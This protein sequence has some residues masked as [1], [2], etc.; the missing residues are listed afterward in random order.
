MNFSQL[1]VHSFQHFLYSAEK[2]GSWG[3]ELEKISVKNIQHCLGE[4]ETIAVDTHSTETCS[5]GR[6]G[7]TVV[8][9]PGGL[10]DTMVSAAWKKV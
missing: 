1:S 10:G 3:R 9:E 2:P 6:T 8:E 5:L 7:N 4:Q